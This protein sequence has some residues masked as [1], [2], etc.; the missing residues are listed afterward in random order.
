MSLIVKNTKDSLGNSV[1]IESQ[2]V[3]ILSA[4]LARF[5]QEICEMACAATVPMEVDFLHRHPQ[6]VHSELFLKPC[7]PFFE[8][9]IENVNWKGVEEKI[10][11]TIRQF[12]L[13]DI[14]K[15]GSEIIEKLK[16]D[17]YYLFAVRQENLLGFAMYAVTPALPEGNVKLINFVV[18]DQGANRGLEKLLIETLLEM[19]P[20]TKRLFVFTRPTN[21]LGIEMYKTLDFSLDLFPFQDPNHPMDLTAMYCLHKLFCSD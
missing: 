8:K 4:E 11:A 5:K 2:K 10:L 17:D 16:N 7:A 14:S 18:S 9:G 15:Y 12:Y 20:T 21:V 13:V 3:D 6:A 1:V 19:L